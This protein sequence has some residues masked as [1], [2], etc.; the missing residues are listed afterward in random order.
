MIVKKLSR[1]EWITLSED[2]HKACFQEIMPVNSE[3]IDFAL[4]CVDE[5]NRPCGYVTCRELDHESV[6]WRYGGSFPETRG[7]VRSWTCYE[8]MT[9]FIKEMGFKRISTLIENK[10]TVM[11]KFA[12][13]IGYLICGLRNYQGLTLLEHVL[14][15]KEGE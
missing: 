5:N 9:N 11:L 14:E 6:Y 4:L 3:K 15:F 1:E 2:A 7:T 10:N 13:K 8:L 12:M